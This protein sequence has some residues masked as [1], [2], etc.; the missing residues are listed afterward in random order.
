MSFQG[1]RLAQSADMGLQPR[2]LP[3]PPDNVPFE[4]KEWMRRVVSQMTFFMNDVANLVN[5]GK[6]DRLRFTIIEQE[7]E[8]ASIFD[9]MVVYAD[10]TS[11]D[12]GSGEGLYERNNGSWQK[13]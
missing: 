3:Q 4:V 5:E 11:W 2:L 13:L 6:F 8:A 1:R 10:G 7:P 9:G 12:P